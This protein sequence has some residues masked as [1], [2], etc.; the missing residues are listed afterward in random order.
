M[1][2]LEMNRI[3]R[4]GKRCPGDEVGRVLKLTNSIIRGVNVPK[5]VS[6]N[7]IKSTSVNSNTQGPKSFF[8]LA[9]VRIIES[10]HKSSSGHQNGRKNARNFLFAFYSGLTEK[11]VHF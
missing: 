4:K 6:L 2:L 11:T 7:D 3:T 9:N 1:F 8:E 10:Y 5:K